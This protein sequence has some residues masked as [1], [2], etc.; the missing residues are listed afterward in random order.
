MN[1]QVQVSD[2]TKADVLLMPAS[3]KNKVSLNKVA[4]KLCCNAINSTT[5]YVWKKVD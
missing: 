5:K 4:H 3:E 2:T 1:L